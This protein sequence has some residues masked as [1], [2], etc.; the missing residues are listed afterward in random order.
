MAFVAISKDFMSRVESKISNMCRAE[1]KT[2]GDKPDLALNP[3]DPFFIST[4][5]KEHAHLYPMMPR[6]WLSKHPEV[7]LKFKVPD[8]NFAD[9]SRNHFGFKAKTTGANQDFSFPP[10]HSYYNTV[11]CDP[12][13]PIMSSILEYAVKHKEIEQRWEKVNIKVV[14]F[15]RACK[16]ANE[17]IKLWPDVKTYFDSEDVKR[18]DVKVVRSGS[19]DSAAAAALANIDTNEM[20]SAA[21]IARLSGAQV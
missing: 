11:V 9:E 12:Y 14:E 4:V 3:S 16:S 20:M 21:V 10:N 19:K 2:L 5:W 17:A 6:E 18:L 15:L 1:L 8:A 13:N 7:S